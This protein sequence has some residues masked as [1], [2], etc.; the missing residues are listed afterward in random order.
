M[1]T[2][3]CVTAQNRPGARL[4]PKYGALLERNWTGGGPPTHLEEVGATSEAVASRVSKAKSTH[5]SSSARAA[6]LLP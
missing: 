1:A 3:H 5:W 6:T 4:Q 2:N